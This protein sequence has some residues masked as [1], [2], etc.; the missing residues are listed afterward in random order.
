MSACVTSPMKPLPPNASTQP[1]AITISPAAG[2]L[3]V[4]SEL[5]MNVVRIEPMIAV[6]M[7]AI[8]G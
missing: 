3:I 6:K 1:I 5:L 2:P 4:S 8:A 7:P